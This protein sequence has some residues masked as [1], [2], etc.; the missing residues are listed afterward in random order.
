[1]NG[2]ERMID[3]DGPK[4]EKGMFLYRSYVCSLNVLCGT[5]LEFI[6]W[7]NPCIAFKERTLYC[8]LGN[9]PCMY[10]QG[11]DRVFLFKEHTRTLCSRRNISRN[12]SCLTVPSLFHLM[13]KPVMIP[14][15]INISN[16]H[17]F[18]CR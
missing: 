5:I 18:L 17:C 3:H 9:A 2:E 4:A 1:M 6:M 13:K 7:N 10:F 14:M 12:T 11:T 15:E 8:F 16:L